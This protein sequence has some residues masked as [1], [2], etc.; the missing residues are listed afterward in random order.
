MELFSQNPLE[1]SILKVFFH[2]K[3]SLTPGILCFLLIVHWLYAICNVKGR[4]NCGNNAYLIRLL[5]IS[6]QTYND[7]I[8]NSSLSDNTLIAADILCIPSSQ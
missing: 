1:I 4:W 7:N 3:I 5:S 2:N 8:T 6:D